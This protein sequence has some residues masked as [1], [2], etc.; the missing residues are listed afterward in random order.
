MTTIFRDK[1]GNVIRT[2]KGTLPR[3]S[4]PS[5]P[6]APALS[7]APTTHTDAA[8]PAKKEK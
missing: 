4:K 7:P 3:G 6:A 1:Q 2:D 8:E 5:K